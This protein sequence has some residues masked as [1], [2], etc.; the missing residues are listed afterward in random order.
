MVQ[1]GINGE[2]LAGKTAFALTAPAGSWINGITLNVDDY[3]MPTP[4]AY[5]PQTDGPIE[6]SFGTMPAGNTGWIS[7]IAIDEITTAAMDA[8]YLGKGGNYTTID[9][10]SSGDFSIVTNSPVNNAGTSNNEYEFPTP[11]GNYKGRCI[12]YY[13]PSLQVLQLGNSNHN[14]VFRLKILGVTSDVMVMGG[15]GVNFTE[16]KSFII[17]PRLIKGSDIGTMFNE[18]K[19]V[20]PVTELNVVGC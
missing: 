8:K 1:F 13:F 15:G 11:A 6:I 3:E 16:N 20:G 12:V 5:N 4:T 9:T 17:I 19:I 2:S 7:P 14:G 18:I 10:A